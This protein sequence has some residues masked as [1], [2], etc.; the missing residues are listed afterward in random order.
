MNIDFYVLSIGSFTQ[1]KF[2]WAEVVDQNLSKEPQICPVC[3]RAISM[4][5]WLP[6]HTVWLKQARTIGDLMMCIGGSDF[7]ASERFRDALSADRLVGIERTYPITVVK[8][9][10]RGHAP[11][12]GLVQ[13]FGFDVRH[14]T[15][16]VDYDASGATWMEE[17]AFNVCPCCGPGGGGAGGYVK[18]L[19]RIVLERDT[20]SGE[21][22]FIPINLSGTILLSHKAAELIRNHKFTNVVT[23]PIEQWTI[24]FGIE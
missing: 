13:I 9:G 14:T 21:D 8:V 6:P 16:R 3:H 22:I 23:I 24:S 1:Y 2:A 11:P 15:C 17:P 12:A 19:S 7:V 20:W 10:S 18:A 4:L 5:R